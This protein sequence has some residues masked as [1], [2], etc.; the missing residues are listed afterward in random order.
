MSFIRY[1]LLLT[2]AVT[3]FLAP[4]SSCGGDGNETGSPTEMQTDS[5]EQPVRG[6]VLFRHLESD[7]KTLNWVLYNTVYELYVLRYLYDAA[8]RPHNSR[9]LR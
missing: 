1:G 5:D 4:L 8:L 2:L 7:C 3:V 9:R 6:G